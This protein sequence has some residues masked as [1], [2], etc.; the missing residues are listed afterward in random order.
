MLG[1]YVYNYWIHKELWVQT[2]R[3]PFWGD[4]NNHPTQLS[5]LEGFYVFTR[6]GY[7][8]GFDSWPEL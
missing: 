1:M 7:R 4:E 6:V 8:R 2:N 5:I 3:I